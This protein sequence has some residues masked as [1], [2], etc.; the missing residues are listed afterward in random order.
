MLEYY[1]EKLLQAICF[2]DKPKKYI[3]DKLLN[4]KFINKVKEFLIECNKN[5]IYN[6]QMKSNLL[7]ITDYY[8]YHGEGELA[9]EFILLINSSDISPFPWIEYFQK[10]YDKRK[11]DKKDEFV[12]AYADCVSDLFYSLEMDYTVLRSL[13]CDDETFNNEFLDYLMLNEFYF[14]SCKRMA[15]EKAKLFNN[16]QSWIRICTINLANENMKKHV[17]K[18]QI[19]VYKRILKTGEKTIKKVIK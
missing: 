2:S 13:I 15:E 16:Q 18:D 4:P 19:K 3:N 7:D 17:N 5:S 11:V 10:E 14:L 9:N 8:R 12:V 6:E 1:Y